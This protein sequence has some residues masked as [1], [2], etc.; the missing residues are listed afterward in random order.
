MR[1]RS[2][3]QYPGVR[4]EATQ[5]FP[6]AVAEFTAPKLGQGPRPEQTERQFFFK[7][8]LQR[9]RDL[10]GPI[11][12]ALKQAFFVLQFSQIKQLKKPINRYVWR[13]GPILRSHY[14]PIRRSHRAQPFY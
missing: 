6:M 8:R 4:K 2:R 10:Q 11:E 7:K 3:I 5:Q 9:R 14:F 12:D 13:K 1:Q